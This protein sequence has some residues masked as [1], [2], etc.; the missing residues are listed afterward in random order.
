M[1]KLYSITYMYTVQIMHILTSNKVAFAQNSWIFYRRKFK[2]YL[3]ESCK[4]NKT[5]KKL[6]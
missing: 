6:C 1:Y 2:F 3:S 5:P 4:I